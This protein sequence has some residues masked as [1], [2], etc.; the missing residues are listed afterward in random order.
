M[1][2][3]SGGLHPVRHI[4]GSGDFTTQRVKKSVAGGD[5]S[6]IYVGDPVR[7]ASNKVT[8]LVAGDTSAGPGPGVFGVVARILV[9]E[10]GRPRVHG[11]SNSPAQHPNVSL[12]A[13]DDWLD[14]YVDTGIVFAARVDGSAGAS[15]VGSGVNIAATARVTAAGISGTIINGTAVS[16]NT[17]PFVVLQ[18]SPFNTTTQA[19]DSSPARVEV[20]INYGPLKTGGTATA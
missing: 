12:T 10:A 8:R 13:D 2:V 4:N 9:T 17:A 20:M 19:G 1:S 15:L 18:V 11:L 5:A 3:L 14:V 16:A 7:L 6:L